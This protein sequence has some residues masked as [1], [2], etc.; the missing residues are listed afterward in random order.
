MTEINTPIWLS[1]KDTIWNKGIIK[2][3]DGEKCIVTMIDNGEEIL[4]NRE[5]IELRKFGSKLENFGHISNR[6][7][8][9]QFLRYGADTA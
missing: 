1:I 6:C 8:Q 2:S 7:L 4:I 9:C 5:N 3:T